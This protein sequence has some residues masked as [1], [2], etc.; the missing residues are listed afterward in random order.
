[1]NKNLHRVVGIDLGTT[2]SAVAAYDNDDIRAKV[3]PDAS[4][5]PLLA[6]STPSVVW[7]DRTADVIVVGHDAKRRL[8]EDP[9]SAVVE[10]KREMGATHTADSVQAV[11]SPNGSGPAA[12]GDP[13]Q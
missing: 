9:G 12:V 11:D 13:V 4:V 3:I 5:D 7:F 6:A 1:M 2:Y 10:I 8:V